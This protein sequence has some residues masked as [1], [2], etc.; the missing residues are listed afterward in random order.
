MNLEQAI[1]QRWAES[2]SLCELLSADRVKTG[3]THVA[4]IPYAT[5][6]RK[7]G[8]TLFRTNAGDALEEV[9]LEIHL[10]HNS[11]DAGQAAADRVK[12]AFDG[13]EF[14]LSDGGRAVQV[15]RDGESAV[16]HDDG[17]WRWT[18]RFSIQ[19]YLSWG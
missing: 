14:I 11:F 8:R 12:T 3:L 10:W 16:E 7:A 4:A 17:V 18:I 6:V 9:P 2:A 5:V 13:G 19:V 15:R 1:H